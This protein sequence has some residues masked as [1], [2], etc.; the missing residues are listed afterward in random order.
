MQEAVDADWRRTLHAIQ[1]VLG[2]KWTLHVLHAL[3][4]EAVGFNE[5]QRRLDGVTAKV[6]SERLQELRCLGFV[7]RE[8]HA[9]VPPSTTYQLTD[10]GE[11]L[12]GT[13]AD[14]ES[15]VDVVACADGDCAMPIGG[16]ENCRDQRDAATCD[17]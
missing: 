4:R 11:R 2:S 1:D 12:A 9:S 14:V 13:L 7:T 17:C 5:L 10:A 16:S 15:M 3:D 8:V 6:L